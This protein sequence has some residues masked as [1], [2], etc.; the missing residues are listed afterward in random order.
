MSPQRVIGL[1]P[2][3]S[4][5]AAGLA[6]QSMLAGFPLYEPADRGAVPSDVD[7]FL[8][9]GDPP[10]VFTPGTAMRH[11]QRFFG[12]PVTACR[13]LGHARIAADPL[14][15][16]DPCPLN[17]DIDM[18]LTP[19]SA[20]CCRDAG[21]W[22]ITVASARQVSLSLLEFHSSS[23]RWASINRTTPLE[24][25]S[26]A[27]LGRSPPCFSPRRRSTTSRRIDRT[28]IRC[29]QCRHWATLSRDPQRDSPD[30]DAICRL[31]E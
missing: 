14:S 6:T 12:T 29:Q 11:G 5:S 22:S 1:F 8:R 9:S 15:G 25:C 27:L 28:A 23:C 30:Y 24:P 16:T 19:A 3:G 7:E 10:I 2:S 31:D 4:L 26:L 17:N 20:N 13:L 21:R 18:F